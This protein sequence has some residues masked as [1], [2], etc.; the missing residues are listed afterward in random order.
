[1][2][3]TH[4]FCI[5]EWI[6]HESPHSL[7]TCIEVT[8]RIEITFN[9]KYIDTHHHSI[10]FEDFNSHEIDEFRP[11]RY[12]SQY[13]IGS[14][15]PTNLILIMSRRSCQVRSIHLDIY[16]TFT[17]FFVKVRLIKTTAIIIE[18]QAKT[19]TRFMCNWLKA[20]RN[21]VRCC[22]RNGEG[23]VEVAVDVST[24]LQHIF[25]NWMFYI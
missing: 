4:I 1:M 9:L 22:Q 8:A 11:C 15:A 12:Q 18:S 2:N 10:H 17:H 16:I 19:D 5:W 13:L 14:K 25:E 21:S 24:F 20:F 23:P 3:T 7:V 6:V